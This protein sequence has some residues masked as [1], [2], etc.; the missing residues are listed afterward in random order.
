VLQTTLLSLA[1]AIILALVAALV[2]P[3]L[4]DWSG[5]RAT[6]EAE[7]GRLIGLKV[8]VS[9]PIAVRLLPSPRLSM[10]GIEI[11]DGEHQIR[12]RSLGIELAL[13]PL[14]RGQWQATDF[15]LVGPQIH[16]GLDASGHLQSPK[17]AV[18][19]NP[20]ALAIDRLTIRD[21]RVTL[22]DAVSG[23]AITLD[24]LSFNGKA[25][26][27][28]GPLNGEGAATVDGA[29]YPFR[30]ATGRYGDDGKLKLHVN[31]NPVNHPLDV[32]ADGTL[33][34]AG[35]RPDFDGRLS[36][37]RP[38]AIASSKTGR[39]SQPWRANGKIKITT[40]RA[41]MQDFALDYGSQDRDFKMTGVADFRFGKQP[42]FDG[43]LSGQQIDL[44]KAFAGGGTPSPPIPVIRDLA[45]LAGGAFRPTI[46][47]QIGI[48][49][50]QV[51][52]G[53]Q[54]V[55][56]LRGDVST[57]A[58]GWN[59]DRFEF[60]APGDTQ[61]RLSGRL[62][63]GKEQVSF[64][65]PAEIKAN[66]PKALA[67][68]LEGHA[69]SAKSE[70]KP[71]S[72]GGRITLASDRIAVEDLKARFAHE[73]VSGHAAYVFATQARPAR[74]DAALQAPDLDI[75]A[76][77]AFGKALLS[78][79][80]FTR[81]QDMSIAAD[82]GQATFAGFEARDA[83]VRL[84]IDG[85]GVRVDKF[86][87]ADFD[88]ASF[89]ASGR[90]VTAPPSPQVSMQV[91]LDAPDMT[92][93][94]T[95]LAHFAPDTAA[96]LRGR[97]VLMA[98]A[99]LHLA[100][101]MHGAAPSAKADLT[102][103]GSLGKVGVTLKGQTTGDLMSFKAGQM[104]MTGKLATADGKMLVGL[105]GLDRLVAVEAAPGTLT[106]DAG[107]P[108]R[109][110]WQVDG[111]LT[112]G[113][114]AAAAHGTA[115]PLAKHP[116][117][118][119]E[120]AILRADAAP[121]RHY[122][123]GALP[124]TFTGHLAIDGH[125]VSL[126]QINAAVAGARLQGNLT[127]S[128]THPRRLQGELDADRLDGAALIAAAAGMP[129]SPAARG[130]AWAWSSDPFGAGVF[131]DYIGEIK[132]KAQRIELLPQFTARAFDATIKFAKNGL[133][134]SDVSGAIA[135]GRLGGS[136]SLATGSDGLN[137]H[138][139]LRLTDADA[140]RLLGSGTN[141]SVTGMLALSGDIDGSGL[142]PVALI[143]SLHGSGNFVLADAQFAGLDPNVFSAA[144]R[145]VDEGLVV[146]AER[147]SDVV[148]KALASGPLPVQRAQGIVAVNDGQARLSQ[149]TTNSMDPKLAI[150]GQLD[151]TNGLIHSRLVLSGRKGAAG[152]APDI[153]LV[154]SGPVTAPDRHIDVGALTNWLT[155]RVVDKQAKQLR[156]IERTAPKPEAPQTK[157]NVEKS[158]SGETP[159]DTTSAMTGSTTGPSIE[160]ASPA[161]PN[162][163]LPPRHD[164]APPL[165]PPVQIHPLPTPLGVANP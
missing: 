88:G 1:I 16:L 72:L 117:A 126:R 85:D 36:L 119:L 75:D 163:V 19:F 81:P 148:D 139:K 27:L 22:S 87:V 2:G 32:T 144:S 157:P 95:L 89:S 150:G 162:I 142:S 68:W 50:D 109:G 56:N 120:A 160:P 103:D 44:D 137:A 7:A 102:V 67:A 65:G 69:S 43:V 70:Y 61:V 158:A 153:A 57:D 114:L 34:L 28:V 134:V 149:F 77:L 108:V 83:S 79:S 73:T 122:G 155:L 8:R 15:R 42:R 86:S 48:G 128:L 80:N 140:A 92:P 66:E 40:R 76:A 105:L 3:L 53:G 37:T 131:G 9:G 165:P 101:A 106:F 24:H 125:S 55:L 123:H 90:I 49:I 20:D 138:A 64:T 6:F 60:R 112:A 111:K 99:K 107:G 127:S 82:I 78:G 84:K 58:D 94:M 35:D 118:D 164:R 12:A 41:L 51:T 129:A 17:L 97:A 151:L 132:L 161:K 146:D 154:L 23:A 71:L 130:G 18:G 47:I 59:L 29:R 63:V 11:G 136:L 100:L 133:T 147:V 145:A 21:G 104:Q 96:V 143:G 74:L 14:M 141:P 93:V 5:Y 31:V 33:T 25:R 135:G 30:V 39:L 121:L 45:N 115:D 52:L 10:D 46:P 116:S 110:R 54:T 98:P 159:P 124:V 91:D 38:V 13:G 26:S 4:I 62:A 156:A 113:G 152:A